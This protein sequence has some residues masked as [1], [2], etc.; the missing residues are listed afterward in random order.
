MKKLQKCGQRNK[1]REEK[2]KVTLSLK[3][4]EALGWLIQ[5]GFI[6]FAIWAF[7]DCLDIG[8]VRAGWRFLLFF[9]IMLLP[10]VMILIFFKPKEKVE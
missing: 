7:Y 9:A 5:I 10:G 3:W 8:S 1:W 6:L 2:M 4:Y